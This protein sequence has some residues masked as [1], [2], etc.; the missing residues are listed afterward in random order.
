MMEFILN[1]FELLQAI[2]SGKS[3]NRMWG[4]HCRPHAIHINY[5]HVEHTFLKNARKIVRNA[6]NGI[7][8]KHMSAEV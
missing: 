3:I 7:S 6:L 1:I 5:N 8:Q 4:I 2:S